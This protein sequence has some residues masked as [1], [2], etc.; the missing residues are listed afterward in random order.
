MGL[1]SEGQTGLGIRLAI[2]VY[3]DIDF[4]PLEQS[5]NVKEVRSQDEPSLSTRNRGDDAANIWH[6]PTPSVYMDLPSRLSVSIVIIYFVCVFYGRVMRYVIFF[7][8]LL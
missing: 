1:P 4:Y 6:R 2:D 5:G 7:S 3:V 8:S